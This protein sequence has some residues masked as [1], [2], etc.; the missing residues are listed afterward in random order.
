MKKNISNFK[1]ITLKGL[2]YFQFVHGVFFS[3]LQVMIDSMFTISDRLTVL[4][5]P[6]YFFQVVSQSFMEFRIDQISLSGLE[7][8][9]YQNIRLSSL[10]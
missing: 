7:I 6:L 2:L 1:N 8:A 10:L 3:C 4:N 9:V 5:F